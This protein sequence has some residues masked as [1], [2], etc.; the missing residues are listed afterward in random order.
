MSSEP[1]FGRVWV[2][3]QPGVRTSGHNQLQNLCGETCEQSF[4]LLLFFRRVF[5]L[6]SWANVDIGH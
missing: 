6:K 1:A 5:S 2:W 4:I 3:W